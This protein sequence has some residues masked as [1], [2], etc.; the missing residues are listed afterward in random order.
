MNINTSMNKTTDMIIEHPD[1]HILNE[2]AM[3]MPGSFKYNERIY[4]N[5][6]DHDDSIELEVLK[7]KVNFTTKPKLPVKHKHSESFSKSNKS[8]SYEIITLLG[9][10]LI[11]LK[12]TD[13]L[14]YQTSKKDLV[15]LFEAKNSF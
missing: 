6:K 9:K 4:K 11:T 10:Q 5:N 13:N 14:F 12:E 7:K 2:D 8:K 1:E 15:S 3:E